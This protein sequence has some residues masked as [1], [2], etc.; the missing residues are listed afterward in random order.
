LALQDSADRRIDSLNLIGSRL[1][2][3]LH[4]ASVVDLACQCFICQTILKQI[5][6]FFAFLKVHSLSVLLRLPPSQIP[7]CRMMQEHF[8]SS[9]EG[10]GLFILTIFL[11]IRIIAGDTAEAGA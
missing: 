11:R 4:H 7:L 5:R 2:K 9:R 8:C 6:F 3:N 10:E 1:H